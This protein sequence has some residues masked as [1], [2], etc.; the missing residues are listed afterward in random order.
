MFINQSKLA[1]QN[2]V[3]SIGSENGVSRIEEEKKT[4]KKKKKAKIVYNL[5][6]LTSNGA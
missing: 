3:Q 2:D 1:Y 6:N 5:P 4:T